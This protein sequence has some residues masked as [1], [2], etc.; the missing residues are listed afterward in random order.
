M[1]LGLLRD[2]PWGRDIRGVDPVVDVTCE[3][4][5]R[6]TETMEPGVDGRPVRYCRLV[7]EQDVPV[8]ELEVH[9]CRLRFGAVAVEAENIGGVEIRPPYRRRGHLKTLM[10]RALAGMSGRV[11]VAAVSDGIR[12]V[13]EKFGFTTAVGEGH[14]VLRVRD[15]ERAVAAGPVAAGPVAAGPVAAGP[16]GVCIRAGAVEDL[17]AMV[18]I[19]NA[20]HARR[21]WTLERPADWNR[22]TR[23][24]TWRP[25]SE[26]RI[27]ESGGRPTGYAILAGRS[28]GDGHV[29]PTVDEL[30]AGDVGTA[31]SLL[32][33][34]ARS[35][36]ELRVGE[37][38]VREPPDGVVGRLAR[39][40]GCAYQQ[41]FPPT[42]GMLARI[43]DRPGLV[44]ALEPE[45]RRRARRP[46][47][48]DDPVPG[49]PVRDD[50]AGDGEAF[51]D[52]TRGELVPDDGLLIRLLLGY[53]SAAD[54]AVLG[55]SVPDHRER[56][57]S[58]WF[59]GGGRAELPTPYAHLLDRY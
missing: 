13:Y 46:P 31:R 27:A 2:P 49:E 32:A 45:L 21:P 33:D 42:G 15:I 41:E 43:L 24:T 48:A 6:Y 4:G 14:L 36:W 11:P 44:A 8:G 20:A 40:M 22:L 53:L 55:A 10:S 50:P 30:A 28:F 23:Q 25:G 5:L 54:A 7:A 57:C 35:A 56:I 16:A 12:D 34:I 17:P 9:S 29:G 58:A 59:P 39:Q 19:Y 18:T 52:L 51:A 38:Q 3:P 47:A 37:F 26:V 1:S